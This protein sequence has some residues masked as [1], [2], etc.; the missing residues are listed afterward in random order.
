VRRRNCSRSTEESLPMPNRFVGMRMMALAMAMLTMSFAGP[1][2]CWAAGSFIRFRVD[3]LPADRGD[4][5]ITA[6]LYVHASPWSFQGLKLT[7][8]PVRETG[9]TPWVDLG[10][11]PGKA[12]GSLVF[13]VPDGAEGITRLSTT[14]DDAGT[15]RDL[16]W[17][18]PDGTRI[19]VQPGLTDV[20]TFREQE[21]RYYVRTLEQT[22]ERLGPLARPPLFFGNAWGR[23]T[24]PAAEYMVKSF[25][26]MGMNCVGTEANQATYET[27]YGWQSQDAQYQPK[28]FLPFDE[29]A[30]LA[31]YRAAYTKFFA[32]RE[33][34]TPNMRIFQLSDEPREIA[35]NA[36]GAADTAGFRRWLA[37]QGLQPADFDVPTWDGVDLLLERPAAAEETLATNRRFYWSRRYQAYLTPRMFALAAQAV[38]ESGPCPDTHSFVALS[39]HALYMPSTMPLDMFELARY[40]GLM[41]GIS[42]WM[43]G[44]SWNWDGHQ[45][46]AFSVAPF[47]AGAR[48]YGREFGGPP[49]SFPMMHCVD[50]TVFR[51]LTQLAN[52][53]KFLSYYTYGP[54]Y[55]ATEGFWSHQKWAAHAVQHVNNQA[56]LV[57]DILGPGTMRPSRVALL[58]SR[59]QEIWRPRQ[60]FPVKRATF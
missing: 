58:Y 37:E 45:A 54:D 23:A 46:V 47:N 20:R 24:G 39:G 28:R 26:L 18:E 7:P 55:L 32:D 57:D 53:C 6:T 59:S 52:Q 2:E 9:W 15:V 50:P 38:R 49:S 13:A 51:A 36:G 1:V 40:P 5:N 17:N 35:L 14:A 4:V 21:R 30:S 27:L 10:R 33:S 43:T 25:R 29:T 8:Q 22:G 12:K 34:A 19:I 42:D 16:A 11:L 48:R 44:G 41:P 56:A 3:R 31:E 60:T